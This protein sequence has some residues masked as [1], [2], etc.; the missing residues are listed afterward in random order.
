MSMSG[1]TVLHSYLKPKIYILHVEDD[2]TNALFIHSVLD[3]IPGDKFS[4]FTVTSLAAAATEI[5]T[6]SP[7][8]ILLDLTVDDSN[9]LETL[10]R[11]RVIAP[12]IPIVVTTGD[13]NELIVQTAIR[14]GAQDYLFKHNINQDLL[15]RTICNAIDRKIAENEM[16][17]KNLILETIMESRIVGYW[18]WFVHEKRR[19]L[20]PELKS[21]LGYTENELSDN[22]QELQR[23]LYPGD[24]GYVTEIYKKHVYSKGT[25]PY[26]Y[27]ARFRHENGSYRWLGCCGKVIV[28]SRDYL[29]IRM[30]GCYIDLTAL[31]KERNTVLSMQADPNRQTAG[32]NS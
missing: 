28:W 18:D 4:I 22:W 25:V 14:R 23:L 8:L 1:K 10:D 3:N 31:E 17:K 12:L 9:G 7:D 16:H 2:R 13:E 27:I 26:R 20:S 15:N 32:Q 24:E 29:P 6:N 11:M 21:M 30:I 19:V 5:A